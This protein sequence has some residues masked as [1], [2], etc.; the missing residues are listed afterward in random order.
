MFKI[1]PNHNRS[2]DQYVDSPNY[3]P[4]EIDSSLQGKHLV[5]EVTGFASNTI[6]IMLVI[7]FI[8]HGGS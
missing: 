4:F 7:T 8:A 2:G 6:L 5:L 1:N 3:L